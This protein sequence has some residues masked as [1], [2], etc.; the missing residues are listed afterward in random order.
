MAPTLY[1]VKHFANLISP[2]V[3]ITLPEVANFA[4]GENFPQCHALA[5]LAKISACTVLWYIHLSVTH[6]PL[7]IHRAEAAHNVLHCK[8]CVLKRCEVSNTHVH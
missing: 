8:V 3:H 4:L 5:K 2:I 1:C 7:H 6:A